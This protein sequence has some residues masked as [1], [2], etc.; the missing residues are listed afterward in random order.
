MNK[1][2]CTQTVIHTDRLQKEDKLNSVT[3]IYLSVKVNKH[4]LQDVE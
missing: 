4:A 1:L 2:K 3:L